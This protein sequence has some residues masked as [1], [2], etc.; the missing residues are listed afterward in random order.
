MKH[1]DK[2]ISLPDIPLFAPEGEL[3]ALMVLWYF[4]VKYE[5]TNLDEGCKLPSFYQNC[6]EKLGGGRYPDQKAEQYRYI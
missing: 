3:N 5:V 4:Y 6:P 1:G 2:V